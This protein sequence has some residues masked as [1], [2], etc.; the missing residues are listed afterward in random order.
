M[1]YV[2]YYKLS[3]LDLLV[4]FSRDKLVR[5]RILAGEVFYE[6]LNQMIRVQGTAYALSGE[7]VSVPI[8]PHVALDG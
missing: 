6:L 3:E 5:P 7:G 4:V 2:A 1:V 8:L